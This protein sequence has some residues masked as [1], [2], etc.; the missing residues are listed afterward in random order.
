MMKT[1]FMILILTVL[2][3]YTF[4]SCKKDSTTEP[5]GEV[6]ADATYYPTGN[7]TF[8]K[9]NVDK[10]DSGNNQTN[11]TRSSIYAGTMGVYQIQ[12]DS[13]IFPGSTTV[14]SVF[15]RKTDTGVFLFLDTAGLTSVIPDSLLPSLT[16]DAE[17]R[18]FLFPM[19]EN[20][21]WPVFKMSLNIFGIT[22]SPA[23]VNAS[24][25]G[26]ENLN[27]NLTNGNETVETVKVRFRLTIKTS[28]LNAPTNYEAFAWVAKNKGIV[29][30]QGCGTIVSAFTGGGIAFADTNSVVTQ[31]V[32]EY[33]IN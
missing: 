32:I 19:S 30:W 29:K 2:I 14:D 9:Y 20:S 21:S 1:N 4:N 22:F 28:P 17:M 15:L 13:L 33:D 18:T 12:L 7:G 10:V 24:Y 27:L 8:Y 23:E 3:V 26:K 16:L 6:V 11:G 5:P 31:N 25:A